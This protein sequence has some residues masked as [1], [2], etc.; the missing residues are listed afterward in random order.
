MTLDT[1]EIQSDFLFARPSFIE[2]V[3]RIVDFGG[4]LNTYNGSRSG[5]EADARALYEDGMAVAHDLRIAVDK[6]RSER[7]EQP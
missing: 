1:D 4:S 7:D 3:A 6:L 2:G 5:E